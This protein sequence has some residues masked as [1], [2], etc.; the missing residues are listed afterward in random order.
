[1][2]VHIHR[3]TY[4][5]KATPTHVLASYYYVPS[6][7]Q[8]TAGR[9]EAGATSTRKVRMT[10]TDSVEAREEDS[11]S[12]GPLSPAR[13]YFSP[14]RSICTC[15]HAL[16]IR[17][18]DVCSVPIPGPYDASC[19]PHQCFFTHFLRLPY[20]YSK[21][22]LVYGVAGQGRCGMATQRVRR[23]HRRRQLTGGWGGACVSPSDADR[24]FSAMATARQFPGHL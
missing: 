15:L 21:D 1:M 7:L 18:A 20:V 5:V 13:A 3:Q 22:A 2:H 9:A 8:S 11:A 12:L 23:L 24:P 14:A 10:Q 17:S 16:L 19:A 4:A 6:I